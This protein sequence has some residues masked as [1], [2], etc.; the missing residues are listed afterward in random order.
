LQAQLLGHQTGQH[1]FAVQ[2]TADE[3]AKVHS[4]YACAIYAGLNDG[5]RAS[6]NRQRLDAAPCVLAKSG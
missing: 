3:I 5:L 6:V 1:F 2:R 4:A